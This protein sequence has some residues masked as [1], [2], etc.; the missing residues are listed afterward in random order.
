MGS[1][2]YKAVIVSPHLDDA[3]FSCGGEIARLTR[4]GRVLVI[5]VFTR[6][7]GEAK[8]YG[9]VVG[10]QRLREDVAA[11]RSLGFESLNLDELDAPFRHEAY[12]SVGKLFRPPVDDVEYLGKLRE[13][14]FSCLAGMDFERIY[15]PLAIGWHVDHMLVYEAF[16]PWATR[17]H[18]YYYEDAPYCLI[19][20]ATRY[21]MDELGEYQPARGDRSLSPVSEV[22]AWWQA[23]AAYADTAMMRNLKP[24]IVRQCAVPVVGAYLYRLM[25]AH[26]RQAAT[27]RKP[28][29]LQPV[30]TLDLGELLEKKLDAMVLY[31]SQFREFFG[32]REDCRA[33]LA[34]YAVRAGAKASALERYWQIRHAADPTA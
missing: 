26:R 24:W 33:S 15:L 16:S 12:R 10:A 27:V 4:Q 28:H 22:Q 29:R 2:R 11:A 34:A 31:E 30:M 9:M 6:Y 21:R 17:A 5:N 13:R 20:H 3:V 32:N 18:C 14:V 1:E 25:A 7:L 8:R 19:P 23:S